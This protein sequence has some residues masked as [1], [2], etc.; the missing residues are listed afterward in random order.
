[1]DDIIDKLKL[2]DYELKFCKARKYKPI[3]R[4]FFAHYEDEKH[5]KA[6]FLYEL[7]YW[8]MSLDRTKKNVTYKPYSDHRK[9]DDAFVKLLADIK[10][11]GI[12]VVNM[13]IDTLSQGYG[14]LP[15]QIVNDLLNIELIRRDYK[16]DDPKHKADD[17]E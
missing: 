12:K 17:E 14:D 7:S 6:E 4:I 13:D 16:F 2:L 9:R 1:M 10:K 8:I 3:S 5:N 11:H 15:C